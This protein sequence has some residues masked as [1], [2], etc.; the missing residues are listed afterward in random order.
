MSARQNSYDCGGGHSMS[1]SP[2]RMS[3]GVATFLMK[4][5]G[6]LFA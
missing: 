1:P 4:F 5:T 3:V 2:T 6:E